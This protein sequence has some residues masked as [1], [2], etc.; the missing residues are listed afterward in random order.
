MLGEP[1]DFT[2]V[3]SIDLELA[4]SLHWIIDN[5]VSDIM[6]L[7]FSIDLNDFGEAK[8]IDLKPNGRDILVRYFD[9]FIKKN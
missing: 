5:D 6:E 9:F 4:N 8:I 2:D 1:L 3:A 7:T